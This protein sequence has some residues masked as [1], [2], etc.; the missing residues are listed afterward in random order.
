MAFC[1]QC[2]AQIK[3][4]AKFCP[5]CGSPMKQAAAEPA[6]APQAPL[7]AVGQQPAGERPASSAPASGKTRKTGVIIACAALIALLIGA[8]VIF[9]P[10]LFSSESTAKHVSDDNRRDKE[11]D[12]RDEEDDPE[13]ED[14]A[15]DE[16]REHAIDTEAPAEPV[17]Q[18]DIL[19][20][21]SYAEGRAWIKYQQE[22]ETFFGSIDKEGNEIFRLSAA[23]VSSVEDF[24][25]D[26]A[27]LAN[28]DG[29]T[30]VID[31]SGNIHYT[32]T[33]ADAG[34]VLSHGGGYALCTH[35]ESSFDSSEDV[36]EI[37]SPDGS[38]EE[39]DFGG[40]YGESGYWGSGIFAI[41]LR[42]GWYWPICIYQTTQHR[43]IIDRDNAKRGSCA[44]KFDNGCVC[45]GI[46]SFDPD[47]TGYRSSLSVLSEDGELRNIPLYSGWNW[48]DYGGGCHDGVVLLNEYSE[49]EIYTYDLA[50]RELYQLD[51]YYATR[52]YK[53][54]TA[55][56]ACVGFEDKST[57]FFNGRIAMPMEG[58]D[59]KH[60]VALF[61]K[62]W[63]LTMDLTLYDSL[64]GFDGNRL[65]ME[66]GGETYVYSGDGELVFTASQ[67]RAEQISAYSDGVSKIGTGK[68]IDENGK[69]L[70]DEISYLPAT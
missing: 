9:L 8:S 34:E 46:D 31:K 67:I 30:S 5:K 14:E 33:A 35:H 48:N 29:S 51:P 59:G 62:Q 23:D 20:S 26:F 7:N 44:V 42:D 11:K 65:V 12:K 52:F 56:P 24:Y 49:G 19:S 1:Y 10:K 68:Y 61:D 3:D 40:W 28:T 39:I 16:T 45:F 69:A 21:T 63:N 66:K 37:Y 13:D 60:Y 50:T 22:D 2:G 43:W 38:V 32:L 47:E 27:Y 64:I 57:G 53:D 58:D 54:I 55:L 15:S 18:R 36:Y 41:A 6:E 70:F 17:V 4:G 25:E